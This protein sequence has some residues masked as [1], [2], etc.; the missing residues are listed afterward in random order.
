MGI[1]GCRSFLEHILDLYG[2]L[3]ADELSGVCAVHL[4]YTLCARAR[5]SDNV[6]CVLV[7]CKR[8]VSGSWRS[9]T[10]QEDTNI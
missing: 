7:H 5:A 4:H 10:V 1:V 9:S 2:R 3:C 8:R 6:R